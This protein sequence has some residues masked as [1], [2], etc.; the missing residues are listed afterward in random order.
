MWCGCSF[1]PSIDHWRY[2]GV[3]NDP[4]W[5]SFAERCQAPEEGAD[6][7]KTPLFL[8][9]LSRKTD[10][11]RERDRTDI[12]LAAHCILEFEKAAFLSFSN[13]LIISYKLN[14]YISRKLFAQQ[15]WT[16][17]WAGGNQGREAVAVSGDGVDSTMWGPERNHFLWIFMDVTQHLSPH[18]EV[19]LCAKWVA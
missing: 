10:R 19:Y 14:C 8:T 13:P 12:I 2:Q 11:E 6:S 3:G 7:T 17:P 15:L 1:R 4:K 18:V 5:R 9:S 16:A